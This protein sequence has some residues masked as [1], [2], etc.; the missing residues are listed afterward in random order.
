M[1]SLFALGYSLILQ[2][3]V[4]PSLQWVAVKPSILRD[5]EI[6]LLSKVKG[7]VEL[8]KTAAALGMKVKPLKNGHLL[9]YDE[10]LIYK[11][12]ASPLT[13]QDLLKKASGDSPILVS[14]LDD[15]AKGY[16]KGLL[17]AVGAYASASDRTLDSVPVHI[18][19]RIEAIVD[20]PSRREVFFLNRGT[21]Q[22]MAGQL[23][24][25]APLVAPGNNA[26]GNA[27]ANGQSTQRQFDQMQLTFSERI[28]PFTKEMETARLAIEEIETLRRDFFLNRESLLTKAYD[29][30]LKDR[31]GADYISGQEY[32]NWQE[33]PGDARS[34]IQNA[35]DRSWQQLG[36]NS[37]QEASKDYGGARLSRICRTLVLEVGLPSSA[38][39]PMVQRM[40]IGSLGNP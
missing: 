10:Q 5:K 19:P 39:N 22:D 20:F 35:M 18:A 8:Q 2:R 32:R 30:M 4:E 7:D 26:A 38:G 6:A 23:A 31:G 3:P 13:L 27:S 11:G 36:W 24:S 25:K 1:V 14:D 16:V 37:P 33:L 9:L 15:E 21:P 17:R 34:K 40:P 28:T 12:E 29:A